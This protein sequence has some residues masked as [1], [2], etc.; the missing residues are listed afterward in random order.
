MSTTLMLSSGIQKE[1][2]LNNEGLTISGSGM[3]EL[4]MKADVRSSMTPYAISLRYD[5]YTLRQSDGSVSTIMF[6][7][8]LI[9]NVL[10]F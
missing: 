4:F 10:V 1:I 3:I 8:P 5:G 6:G 7:S 2:L 9:T